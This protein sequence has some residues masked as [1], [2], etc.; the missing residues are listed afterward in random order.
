MSNSECDVITDKMIPWVKI[1]RYQ[2]PEFDEKGLYIPDIP[3][4]MV[5]WDNIIRVGVSYEIHPIV[6]LEWN[7]I[8]FQTDKTDETYWVEIDPYD[9][10]AERSPRDPFIAEI[11]KRYGV[12]DFPYLPEGSIEDS[13]IHSYVIWPES[14]IGDTMYV[15]VKRHWWSLARLAYKYSAEQAHPSDG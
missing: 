15:Y 8:A 13:H 1:T 7:Y 9:A 12:P 2:N 6:I 14:E 4:S 5:F 11:C 10:H 3:D